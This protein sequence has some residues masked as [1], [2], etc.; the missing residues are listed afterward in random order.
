M[1][2]HANPWGTCTSS[3]PLPGYFPADASTGRAHQAPHSLD[4]PDYPDYLSPSQHYAPRTGHG[5]YQASR[6]G[7]SGLATRHVQ[8][9]DSHGRPG[10]RFHGAWNLLELWTTSRS[11]FS[12][13]M[14]SQPNVL[15]RARHSCRRDPSFVRLPVGRNG[16]RVCRL[17]LP[18][19]RGPAKISEL[20]D[21]GGGSAHAAFQIH[22]TSLKH[23]TSIALHDWSVDG[24]QC[25]S[26]CCPINL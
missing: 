16:A 20:L 9:P 15:V 3:A 13:I 2:S 25:L 7:F 26:T 1:S 8:S 10:I 4:Y 12:A 22:P 18:W 19:D 23:C 14:S 21:L 24:Q 11:S 5:Y 17:L 6:S